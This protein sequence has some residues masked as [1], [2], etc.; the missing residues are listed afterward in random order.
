MV[1]GVI[2]SE[3]LLANQEEPCNFLGKFYGSYTL[4]ATSV[5][6]SIGIDMNHVARRSVKPSTDSKMARGADSSS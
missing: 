3:G 4:H 5:E 1:A 2:A 6:S